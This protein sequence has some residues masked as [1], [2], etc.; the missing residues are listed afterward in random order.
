M[1]S[2]TQ[3]L[4]QLKKQQ[5]DLEERIKKEEETKQKL[6]RRITALEEKNQM[7]LDE[8]DSLKQQVHDMHLGHYCYSDKEYFPASKFS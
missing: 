6:Q 1:T 2:L 7:L 5:C 4:E 3:Q 8:N